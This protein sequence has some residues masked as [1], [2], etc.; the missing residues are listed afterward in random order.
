MFMDMP[1]VVDTNVPAAIEVLT[2]S[3][4]SNVAVTPLNTTYLLMNSPTKPNAIALSAMSVSFPVP[5]G[6]GGQPGSG[7]NVKFAL[8]EGEGWLSPVPLGGGG[9]SE[10]ELL[11]ISIC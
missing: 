2:I 9:T 5:L 3:A 11:T 1:P 6:G 7:E 4:T 10:P 8:L